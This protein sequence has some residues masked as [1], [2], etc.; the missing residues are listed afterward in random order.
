[1]VKVGMDLGSPS[2]GLYL[3]SQASFDICRNTRSHRMWFSNGFHGEQVSG[4][5][6]RIQGTQP[7][8][9]TWNQYLGGQDQ[10][11]LRSLK[12]LQGKPGEDI[13]LAHVENEYLNQHLSMWF[14]SS[15]H[16]Y[17]FF[18]RRIWTHHSPTTLMCSPAWRMPEPCWILFIWGFIGSVE[19]MTSLAKW[20]NATSSPT[21][22]PGG[23]GIGL[24][25]LAL[26]SHAWSFW[27]GQSLPGNSLGV[28]K[29]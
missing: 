8:Y 2:L 5:I 29:E 14:A 7:G 27:C 10:W 11:S 13:W 15:C 12:R 4:N 24:K 20:L 16:S 22:L 25:V 1:M 18:S 3:L 6:L 28:H 9:T 17:I 23:W 21:P 19:L 26:W